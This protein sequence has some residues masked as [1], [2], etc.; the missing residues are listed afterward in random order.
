MK[1][2][3]CGEKMKSNGTVDETWRFYVLSNTVVGMIIWMVCMVA[4]VVACKITGSEGQAE[5]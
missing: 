4:Y 2:P 1:C 3:K 5:E